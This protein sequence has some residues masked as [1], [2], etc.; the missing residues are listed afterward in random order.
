[1]KNL[2]YYEKKN[3]VLG[4]I[5]MSALITLYMFFTEEFQPARIFRTMFPVV[6]AVFSVLLVISIATQKK[7]SFVFFN[8]DWILRMANVLCI[9]GLIVGYTFYVYPV[10]RVDLQQSALTIYVILL[11]FLYFWSVFREKEPKGYMGMGWNHNS[12]KKFNSVKDL[13]NDAGEEDFWKEVMK[14]GEVESHEDTKT[15]QKAK[16]EE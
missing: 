12:N 16:K 13:L 2:T 6:W 10:P 14:D 9:V 3:A 15:D 7:Y 11:M 5:L 8:N 4:V 1:M